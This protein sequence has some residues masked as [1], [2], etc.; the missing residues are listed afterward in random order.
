M[1]DRIKE[2]RKDL[3]LTQ[4]EFADRLGIKRNTVAT[5]EIGRNAPIDTVIALIC[6]RFNVREEWLR[7]GRGA[8]YI[9]NDQGDEIHRMVDEMLHDENAVI[10]RRLVS[11][12]LRLSPEQIRIG[13][14]W[15]RQTFDIDEK[16]AAESGS[17]T[18]P[19]ADRE[20]T[21]DE[22]VASYRAELEAEAE[23][24]RKLEASPNANEAN[25]S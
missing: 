8:M 5:Y 16:P 13:V 18:A 19:A 10:K 9:S 2:L 14:E 11:A 3:G 23:A 4:Q 1:K 20:P 24:I 12:I 7:E 15:M 6:D 25:A 21:I 17:D 22:K